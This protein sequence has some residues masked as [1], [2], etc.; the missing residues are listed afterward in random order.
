MGTLFVVVAMISIRFQIWNIV[1]T[2]LMT[3]NLDSNYLHI[4]WSSRE[5][6][7]S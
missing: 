6:Q 4:S 1:W 3:G 2:G 5:Q 7:V